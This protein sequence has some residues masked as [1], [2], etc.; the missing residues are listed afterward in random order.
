MKLQ[1]YRPVL[2]A[3]VGLTLLGG[4]MSAA[5][6]SS[7]TF[8]LSGQVTVTT[9]MLSFT[10]TG[11][12][13]AFVIPPSMGQFADLTPGSTA[14]IGNLTLAPGGPVTVGTPF[15]LPNWVG[16]PD[17]VSLDLSNI[18]L[19][20]VADVPLCTGTSADNT[21][22]NEC[23]AYA[24]SPIVLS[25][26]VD[27]VRASMSLSGTAHFTGT[28]STS[29]DSPFV[30]LLSAN[31]TFGPDN[32]ISGLL[33]DFNSHGFVTTG[34]SA[35]FTTTAATSSVPEPGYLAAVGLGL[36]AVGVWKKRKFV[37]E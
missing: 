4:L 30:G 8:N 28:A 24:S 9:T 17:G 20:S 31:F 6:V 14:T 27:G 34:Y 23:R 36:L 13:N 19:P 37:S 5:S 21:P 3:F 35:N 10:G 33:S 2:R 15:S 16:L 32:T 11:S 7:G 29:S 22:G 26:S 18:L 1:S 25:Q 12:G